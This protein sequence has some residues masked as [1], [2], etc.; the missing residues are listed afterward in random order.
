M[1]DNQIQKTGTTCIALKYKEGVILA[2]DR[3][4]T[5]GYIVSDDFEKIS[6]L[7]KRVATTWSGL[8]SDAQIY[9]R[10]IQSEIKLKELKTEREILVKEAASIAN[11]LQYRN[12]RT[13]SAVQG[14]VGYLVGGYDDRKGPQI[15]E[16]GA[17][18]SLKEA[19]KFATNGSGSIFIMSIL[20]SEYK[21]NMSEKEATQLIERCL[22]GAMRR[23]NAS[24]GGIVMKIINKEGIREIDK[25]ILKT[26]LIVE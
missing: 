9:S 12:I 4:I 26:E 15:F 2:T 25:K 21:D 19:G 3:R 16:V 1:D 18:G 20:D 22:R 11:S 6:V 17:D 23:D 8:L 14:I 13:P 7:G 10:V 5:A 24:G